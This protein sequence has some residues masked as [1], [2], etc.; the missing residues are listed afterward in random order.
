MRTPPA[1]RSLSLALPKAA[2]PPA[3]VP[4]DRAVA[5]WLFGCGG[6][7]AGMVSVGGLTRLTRSG[8]SMTDWKL[9]GGLPPTNRAEWEREFA[10][11]KLYP[12]WQQRQ[13]MTLDEFKYIYAWEYGH[14][15]LGR[16]VGLAFGLPLAYFWT[17]GRL[18]P[19]LKPRAMALLGLGGAQGLI[20]WWM[21][22]S[23]L[24]TDLLPDRQKQDVR[25]SP[26]RLATH[27][28]MAFITYSGLV[29]C[30]LEQMGGQRAVSEGV[31][32]AA[33]LT[34]VAR[35]AACLTLVTAI[36]GA[37]VA[38][39]DAGMAFNVWPYM[40][41]D[42]DIDGE[43]L[44]VPP[45]LL[46]LRPLWRNMFENTACVQFD[47]RMLAYATALS[48][49]GLLALARSGAW[50]ALPIATRRFV[51]AGALA[52]VGQASLGVATLLYVVPIE[53][54]AAHQLGGIGLLTCALGSAHSL[55]RAAAVPAVVVAA[56]L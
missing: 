11:Y 42:R 48:G 15:M 12:E 53:L 1:R 54:A 44:F 19:W 25:V 24:N 34:P 43:A 23:G 31:K 37:F 41:D 33:K 49:T 40:I 38:G 27:L 46:E 28:T 30:G 21:V 16:V 51:A 55:A 6:L 9:Q 22:R 17:R 4:G 29:W 26:Y 35:G 7:V 32:H 10:R 14:R 5:Y 3:A 56:A 36:S 50:H 13:S 45:D 39:N 8:L 52:V 2:A 47:H 20:G 18:T